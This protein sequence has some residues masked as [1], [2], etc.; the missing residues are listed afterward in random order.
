MEIRAP[1]FPES[2]SE[3]ELT[4]WY[5]DVGDFVERDELLADV[6]TEKTTIEIVAQ[7][8]G[9]ISNLHKQEGDLVES[10]EV[11]CEI[12]ESATAPQSTSTTETPI[13]STDE[14]AEITASPAARK[15]ATEHDLNI[16][17]VNGTG[18]SGMVTKDDVSKALDAMRQVSKPTVDEAS[19][20]LAS[21]R[22]AE[23]DASGVDGTNTRVERR[24]PMTRLRATIAR[25]LVE[26]QQTSAMLTTFNEANMDPIMRM[27]R[28]YQEEFVKRHNGTRL[29]F[30]SFFVRAAV[31]ALK[32]FPAVN[33]SIDG[34]DVVYHGYYDI[35][36]AVSTERGLVVPVVRDA[37][38]LGL[39]QIED[40]IVE[41][42]QKARDNKLAIDDMTGGTFT[43]SNGGVFGSLLSTPILNP[44]QTA[45]LGMH[46]IQDRPVVEDGEIVVRPMMYLALSYDH[47]LIDGQ[48]AV[49]FLV[50]IKGMIEDPARILLEL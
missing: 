5:H 42:G 1:K 36:V 32:R 50:T 10:E 18:R 28:Q 8:N 11:L 20:N 14:P 44:P 24:L 4:K 13:N 17:L 7:A 41:F 35:G 37:D 34:E 46:A 49:R 39:H 45:I 23:L 2:I 15:L 9:V 16:A 6:E 38:A 33:A 12:D 30:M 48:E 31:E 21:E 25:R 26:V 43:I 29:G 19:E 22:M 40:Q 27:R 47:R 3:G